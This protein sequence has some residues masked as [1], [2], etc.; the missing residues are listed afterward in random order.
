MGLFSKKVKPGDVIINNSHPDKIAKSHPLAQIANDKAVVLTTKEKPS[1]GHQTLK[2]N[3]HSGRGFN[4]DK[5]YATSKVVDNDKGEKIG[6]LNGSETNR[7]K[8]WL[9]K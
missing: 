2:L 9:N 3:D 5:A 1:S 8:Q 4:A 7:I 6:K